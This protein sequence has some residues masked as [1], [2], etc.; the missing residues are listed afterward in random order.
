[1]ARHGGPMKVSE[2]SRDFKGSIKRL[3]NS[4]NRWKYLLIISLMLAMISSILS[5]IG[6]NKLSDLTDTITLGI[7]PNILVCRTEQEIPEG[8]RDG[9]KIRLLGQGKQG[10]N[11]GKNGDALI[12][13]KVL[14]HK[15][16]KLDGN[17]VVLDV[18]I[19]V[20]EAVLGAKIVVPT[21]NGKVNLNIPQYSSSGDKLRLRGKGIKT[22]SGVGDQIVN[23]S[24]VISKNKD[25][26][27][28]NMLK[29]MD[30]LQVRT[31]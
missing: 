2:K 4:L 6:P 15:Y 30:D 10:E 13:I 5:L 17:N 16:F 1:M 3:F 9:E 8:I 14:P 31:F 26:A 19:S 27:L 18:P 7:Q 29:N 12:T 20:K 21:I 25:E 24:V 22:K 11:G 23:L 28:E